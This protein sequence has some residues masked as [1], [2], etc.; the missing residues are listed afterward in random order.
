MQTLKIQLAGQNT[1]VASVEQAKTVC[2]K[3]RQKI[4]GSLSVLW[5]NSA[6]LLDC[7]V[8]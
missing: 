7:L 8:R 2:L 1:V 4:V 3:W 5:E 6:V